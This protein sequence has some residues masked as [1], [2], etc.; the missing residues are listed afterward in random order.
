MVEHQKSAPQGPIANALVRHR[1]NLGA[2]ADD[3]A[4]LLDELVRTMAVDT[5]PA[6]LSH[7]GFCR[8]RD[9][10]TRAAQLLVER[11]GPLPEIVWEHA[12]CTC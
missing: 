5:L 12:F 3:S 9:A 1:A 6:A 10:E 7:Q 4:T 8:P 2:Y 11:A